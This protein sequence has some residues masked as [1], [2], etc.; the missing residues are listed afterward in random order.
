MQD[1]SRFFPGP[2]KEMK[3]GFS[4]MVWG[5]Q[6]PVVRGTCNARPG[7]CL[8]SES[9]IVIRAPSGFDPKKE[10]N[11][12]NR[13]LRNLLNKRIQILLEKWQPVMGVAPAE[14]R[15]KKMK[16]RW[17]SC[18]TVAKRIW[19]NTVF[20]HLEPCLLEYVLVHE[21]VHLL[22]PGHTRRFYQIMEIYLPDWKENDARLNT[23][24]LR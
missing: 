3:D 10:A 8:N 21:L 23:I 24:E 11:L 9:E 7:I 19:I 2:P 5:R 16:T 22:E 12:W 4:C 14:F 6:L 15:L 18:N 20:V 1:I 17:G 13:W